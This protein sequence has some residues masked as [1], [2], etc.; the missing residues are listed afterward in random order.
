MERSEGAY[1]HRSNDGDYDDDVCYFALFDGFA[2]QSGSPGGSKCRRESGG[3]PNP[4]QSEAA[5]QSRS[6]GP[7]NRGLSTGVT[8]LK[9][10]GHGP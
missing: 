1:V 7:L 4:K 2:R 6:G 9:Q 10:R 8:T 5:R 3:L